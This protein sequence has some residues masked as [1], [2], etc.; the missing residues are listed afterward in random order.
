[1]NGR[2]LAAGLPRGGALLRRALR[3]T[4]PRRWPIRWWLPILNAAI[5][6]GTLLALSALLIG[7]LDGGLQ[8]Q[9][10]DYL[11]NQAT[12]ILERELGVRPTVRRGGRPSFSIRTEPAGKPDLPAK[13][14]APGKRGP[15]DPPDPPIDPQLHILAEN[16]VRE[17]AGRDTGIVVY[18]TR[19]R[20]VAVSNP[21]VGVER[22]PNA[23]RDVLD[24][25]L[26]GQEEQRV[27][28]QGSRRTLV[29]L[30]P[31]QQTDGSIL[32]ALEVA[33][34]LEYTDALRM[35]LTL[36]LGVGTVLTVLVV[37]GISVWVAR[38][39]L[40]PLEQVVQ[41]TRT[42]AAGDLGARVRLTRQDEVGEL[43]SAFDQ[44]VSRLEAAFAA[45]RRLVSDAAHELR[46]PLNGLAGTLEIVQMALAR[47]DMAQAERLLSSVES[48]LDRLGR[49]V[50]DLLT[51][52][53][54]DEDSG[55][56]KLIPT[57]LE[58]VLRDVVR[59]A[60]ILAPDHEIATR[61]D[62]AATVLGDR[63]QLERVFINLLDNAVKYTP[64]GGHV[65][66]TL[67]QNGSDVLASVSDSGRGIEPDELPRIF[68][69]FYR[70]DRARSR[71][72]GG[73]GLGLAIVQ[74]IVHAHHGQIDAESAIGQGTTVQV[75]L[76]SAPAS[77]SA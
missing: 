18:D 12:P 21:G 53:R 54:L 45:Q 1:M 39:A 32:G 47:E 13:P 6:G 49:F 69:R 56:V 9:L 57:P 36:V 37:G 44:M 67:R 76:P 48:E 5:A 29:L 25:V 23:P 8:R 7:L 33:T 77:A 28:R 24:G 62:A 27:L 59:R 73:T 66:V 11:R 61:L 35:Q 10:A 63:D 14:D 15:L 70:V 22:W 51:L 26:A 68:D 43:A 60:R 34:S 58:P 4:T 65:E 3:L 16:F 40:G 71:Q 55:A 41:V 31:L 74:A 2:S 42:V 52:S 30:I 38:R 50:N 20:V 75:R 46:T 19:R 72:A 17:L 64:P